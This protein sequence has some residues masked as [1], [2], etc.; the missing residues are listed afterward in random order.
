MV[1]RFSTGGVIAISGIIAVSSVIV[2]RGL[3]ASGTPT[4]Q[5]KQ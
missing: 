1:S 2:A 4:K 5:R 3:T